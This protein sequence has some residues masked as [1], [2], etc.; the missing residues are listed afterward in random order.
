MSSTP[1]FAEL[2]P[3]D[4]LDAVESLGWQCDG[5]LL[6]LNS[7]ENR[8]YQVGIDDD[9]PVIAKFYRNG[10]WSD[11]QIAEEHAFAGEA[12]ERDLPVV[13]P[14]EV[15]GQSLHTHAG[16]RFSVSPRHGG[17]APP[18]DEP[19]SLSVLG[20]LLG[21]LHN[22]GAIDRFDQRP[23]IDVE[24][25]G[26]RPSRAVLTGD[27][28]PGHLASAYET[29]AD[30]LLAR[31]ETAFAAVPAQSLRLHG[32]FHPGNVIWRDHAAIIVDLDDARMGPAIQ[33]LWM[34]LPGERAERETALAAL[35]SGYTDF[36]DFDPLELQLIEP[37]RTLRLI[38]YAGW[39]ATRAD[40]PA[41]QRAFPWLLQPKWWEDHVLTLREQMA[42]LDEPVLDW[43]P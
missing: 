34:F 41:F 7:F 19:A 28:L 6:Q 24:H 43:R 14:C 9:A 30:D 12:A 38:H 2:G 29:L 8:V 22:V 20:R 33:D 5:R 39:I 26:R 4:V 17:H 42:A 25:F 15:A 31:I 27:L 11:A 10:R 32:D 18:L 40:E 35:L 36:R 37:L 3:S 1:T 13:A 23:R 21:R 16:F